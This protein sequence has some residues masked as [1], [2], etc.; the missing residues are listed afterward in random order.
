MEQR[1]KA[2]QDYKLE[3]A[4]VVLQPDQSAL[5]SAGGRLSM[6]DLKKLFLN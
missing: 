3:I 2:L 1:M 6:E 5:S 4:N